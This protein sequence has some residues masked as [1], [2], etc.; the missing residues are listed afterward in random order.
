[1]Q[2][3][4]PTL[5][6]QSCSQSNLNSSWHSPCLS[7]R[8]TGRNVSRKL[9]VSRISGQHS[10]L[11]DFEYRYQTNIFITIFQIGERRVL[12]ADPQ[13]QHKSRI[14]KRLS[15]NVRRGRGGSSFLRPELRPR[16]I[17]SCH[18]VLALLNE[19][20]IR[21]LLASPFIFEQHQSKGGTLIRSG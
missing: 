19:F 14:K 8:S 2:K 7:I 1:M 15:F 13:N 17:L 20:R 4:Q 11:A 18:G 6:P 16:A 9:I 3:V 10:P 5:R 12:I 21:L